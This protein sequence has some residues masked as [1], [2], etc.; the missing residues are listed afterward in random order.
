MDLCERCGMPALVLYGGICKSCNQE[1]QEREAEY[2]AEGWRRAFHLYPWEKSFRHIW[3]PK[4]SDDDKLADLIFRAW[5]R[6][7]L[8]IY[9]DELQSLT[10]RFPRATDTLSDVIRT[11]RSRN[12]SVWTATQRPAWVPRWFLSES[13]HKFIFTLLDKADRER[14]ADVIGDMGRERLRMH[15][16]L[17]HAPGMEEARRLT[18]DLRRGIIRVVENVRI[19]EPQEG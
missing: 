2:R 19:A 10:D 4:R 8:T 18:Y 1:E 15:T 5:K 3:V 12:V 6:K 13:H 16:F 11:G 17:Y 7:N 9:V 14:A